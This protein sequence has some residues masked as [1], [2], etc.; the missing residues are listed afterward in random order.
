MR[1]SQAALLVVGIG[2]LQPESFLPAVAFGLFDALGSPQ[3]LVRHALEQSMDQTFCAVIA[4]RR[5]GDTSKQPMVVMSRAT[6]A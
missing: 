6:R 4:L 1:Q 3:S 2:R 5:A